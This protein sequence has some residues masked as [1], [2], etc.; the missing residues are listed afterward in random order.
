MILFR[1]TFYSL[2][3]PLAEAF[4]VG[5]KRI[6]ALD[7]KPRNLT[8]LIFAIVPQNTPTKGDF[9][10]LELNQGSVS[11]LSIYTQIKIVA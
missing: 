2:L 5:R 4:Y 10:V 9:M 11:K 7:F 3:S 8:G 6:V 1:D